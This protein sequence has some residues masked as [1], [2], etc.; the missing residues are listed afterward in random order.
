MQRGDIIVCAVSGD[1]GKPRLQ[2]LFN[3]IYLIPLMQ[4]F[5]FVLLPAI[6][7]KHRYFVSY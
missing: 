6:S 2:L 1:Y 5:V 4:V 3:R 7:L